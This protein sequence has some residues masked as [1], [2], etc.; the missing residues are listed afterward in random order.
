MRVMN[1]LSSVEECAVVKHEVQCLGPSIRL[2]SVHGDYR[3][4]RGA[5]ADDGCGFLSAAG[6]SNAQSSSITNAD[7]VHIMG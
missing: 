6:G 3:V 2:R 1:H 7:A 5:E 4:R